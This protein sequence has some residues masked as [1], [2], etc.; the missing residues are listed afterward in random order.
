MGS[1]LGSQTGNG[2]SNDVAHVTTVHFGTSILS[3]ASFKVI[4]PTST[5]SSDATDATSFCPTGSSHLSWAQSSLWVRN[6][7]ANTETKVLLDKF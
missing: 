1:R 3:E 2:L 4:L 6:Y 5:I 7:V